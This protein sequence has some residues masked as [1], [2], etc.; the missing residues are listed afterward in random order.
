MLLTCTL[1]VLGLMYSS[2]PIWAFVRPA[3]ISRRTSTS[4][5]VSP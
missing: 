5:L 1:A 2:A 3:A 4:R